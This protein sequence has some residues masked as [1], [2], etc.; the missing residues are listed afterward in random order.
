MTSFLVIHVG[1]EP[2]HL[3]PRSWPLSPKHSPMPTEACPELWKESGEQGWRLELGALS[4]KNPGASHRW[5]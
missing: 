2:T 5:F 3:V 1:R 4:L